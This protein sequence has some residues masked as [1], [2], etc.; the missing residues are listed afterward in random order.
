MITSVNAANIKP[1]HGT[2][3]LE[4]FYA[5]IRLEPELSDYGGINVTYYNPVKVYNATGGFADFN[6]GVCCN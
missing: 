4:R 6:G 3:E 5:T 1:P 2:F